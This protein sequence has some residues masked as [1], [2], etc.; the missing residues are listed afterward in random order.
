MTMSY[1]ITKCFIDDEYKVKEPK[2]NQTLKFRL[3]DDDDELYFEG[4]MTPTKSESL[5]RP[6]DAFMGWG[7][8]SIKIKSGNTW[9][10][11]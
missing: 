3:Y 2:E 9:E 6:L 10:L 11:V 1:T 4:V 5:F 8:T 7:C